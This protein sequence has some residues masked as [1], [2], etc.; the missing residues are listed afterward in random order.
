MALRFWVDVAGDH[1]KHT[2]PLWPQRKILSYILRE[3]ERCGYAMR[4]LDCHAQ[5]SW[6]ASPAFLSKLADAECEAQE[7]LADLP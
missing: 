3:Y 4:F 7:D 5:V 1:I 2:H 6:Q